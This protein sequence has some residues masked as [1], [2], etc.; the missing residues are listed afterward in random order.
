MGRDRRRASVGRRKRERD[1]AIRSV[2]AYTVYIVRESV[3]GG[4][5]IEGTRERGSAKERG[6]RVETRLNVE[7]RRDRRE[8]RGVRSGRRRCRRWWLSSTTTT[9]ADARLWWRC[10][11]I[12]QPP[13]PATLSRNGQ[14]SRSRGAIRVYA[15]VFLP[16]PLAPRSPDPTRDL[17]PTL[18]CPLGHQPSVRPQSPLDRRV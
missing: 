10:C 5:D 16:L 9:T 13:S 17:R 6:I 7:P 14:P 8:R 15:L 18:P 11:C 4:E 2:N 3:R 1:D 12:D